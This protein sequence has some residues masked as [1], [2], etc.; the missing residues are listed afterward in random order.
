MINEKVSI[1]YAKALAEIGEEQNQAKNFLD[2][3]KKF[4]GLLKKFP[5]LKKTL[6]SP[7]YTAHDQKEIVLNITSKTKT[8]KAIQSFLLL[9]IEK[10]RVLYFDNIIEAYESLYNETQGYIKAKIITA[11][12]LLQKEQDT[13]KK[14]LENLMKRKVILTTVVEPQIIGGVIAEVGDKIFDGS[15]KNQIK[16]IGEIINLKGL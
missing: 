7:L 12:T 3:L 2:E 13:I 4:S 9:L 16:K 15:I 1:R 11:T 8:P 14:S 5:E 10:R 6:L